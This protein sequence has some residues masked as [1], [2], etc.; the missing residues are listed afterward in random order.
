[1]NAA[2]GPRHDAAVIALVGVAHGFSHFLQLALPPLFPLLKADL[3]YSYTELGLLMTVFF[4]AS[5][6]FQIPAGFVVDRIGAR[7]VLFCGLGCLAGATLLY[8]LVPIYPVLLL[9]VFVAGA[10][11]SVFHPADFSIL[12]AGVDERRMGRAFSIHAFAGFAGYGA[13][14]AGI[15]LLAATLGWRETLIAVGGAGLAY[16]AVLVAARRVLD[17]GAPAPRPA[18]A[19]VQAAPTTTGA[20]LL[21]RLPIVMFFLFFVVMAMAQIGFQTFAP[22]ALIEMYGTSL[23]LANVAV[24]A[25]LFGTLFG[26]LVGG[27]L[28]DRG[29]RHD[30]IAGIF[31]VAT[32][33]TIVGTALVSLPDHARMPLFALA[34]VA[35]GIVFPSRDMLVRAAA[36]REATGK[37]F[38]FVYSGL[39]VGSALIPVA[40]GWLLDRGAAAWVFAVIGVCFALAIV[41]LSLTPRAAARPAAA[42]G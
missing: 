2:P 6:G 12:S 1:M 30:I 23:T 33:V 9:L 29:A 19:A 28:A 14:P 24:T 41:A 42:P 8:G 18:G 16:L 32:A 35:F 22:P 38:G 25:F 17:A 5:G 39:D 13:A 20:S 31:T 7:N 37:V 21:L 11:N 15:V 34:G 10:G 36:P 27:V 4:A 3:G 26:V 40:M